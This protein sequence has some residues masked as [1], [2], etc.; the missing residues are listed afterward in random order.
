LRWCEGGPDP[1]GGNKQKM[2]DFVRRLIEIMKEQPVFNRRH[3]FRGEPIRGGFLKDIYWLEPSGEE[4]S[5]EAWNAGFVRCLGMGLV[6]SFGQ[7]D[8]QGRPV[9]GDTLALLLNAHHESID[10]RLPKGAE[11]L[12]M[13]ERLFDTYDGN[14]DVVEHDIN[15]PY[16]LRGRSVAM[17]RFKKPENGNSNK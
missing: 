2:L 8:A 6:G 13:L 10:F 7:V 16:K 17:F 3:F 11:R 14:I 1:S 9:V 4:M 12:G 15:F 5:D